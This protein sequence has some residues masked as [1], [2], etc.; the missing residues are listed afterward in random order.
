VSEGAS[1]DAEIEAPPPRRRVVD[2]HA[3]IAHEDFTPRSF[4]DG[5]ID[6]L[7]TAMIAR[8]MNIPRAKV[9]RMFEKKM[10]DPLCDTLIAEM[11]AAGVDTSILLAADFSYALKDSKL[12]VEECLRRH[13]E[14]K[15]RHGDRLEVFGGIDPRWG[16][17]GLDLFERSL[18]EWG[19]RGLKL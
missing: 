18:R 17:D 1:D 14:V 2:A 12:T 3:H 19:F 13:H 7:Q 15:V 8:G 16:K 6:N 9:Q 4:I 10:Q 5:S 11:D